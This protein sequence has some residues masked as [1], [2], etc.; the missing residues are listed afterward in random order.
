MP[1]IGYFPWE[2]GACRTVFLLKYRGKKRR[3]RSSSESEPG[4]GSRAGAPLET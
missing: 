1:K 3:K 4:E 2:C